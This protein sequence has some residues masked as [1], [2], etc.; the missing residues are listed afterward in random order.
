MTVAHFE[1]RS[2]RLEY[3][4]TALVEWRIDN[5][6]FLAPDA[7]KESVSEKAGGS[8]TPSAAALPTPSAAALQRLLLTEPQSQFTQ[9]ALDMQNLIQSLNIPGLITGLL[10]SAAHV[11]EDFIYVCQ[12][13]LSLPQP[14]SAFLR[15]N[16]APDLCPAAPAFLLHIQ[17]KSLRGGPLLLGSGLRCTGVYIFTHPLLPPPDCRCFSSSFSC[18]QATAAATEQTT[19]TTTTTSAHSPNG[20]KR[21][22]QGRSSLANTAMRSIR[23]PHSYDDPAFNL[24]ARIDE[25]VFTYIRGKAIIAGLVAVSASAFYIYIGL[26]MW[27]VFAVL[28]FFLNFIP[29]V[30]LFIAIALPMVSAP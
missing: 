7:T 23:V 9:V 11:A 27:L 6:A 13:F 4:V 21:H 29:S 14:S 19:T 22:V 26:E 28:T 10:G 8:P 17:L 25:Q 5:L 18:S 16:T 15:M 20:S 24:S 30:G 1:T 12:A 2:H 3:L